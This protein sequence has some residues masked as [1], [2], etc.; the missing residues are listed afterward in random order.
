MEKD[1]AYPSSRGAGREGG[2]GHG[3]EEFGGDK[4]VSRG[5]RVA[6]G[7]EKE[8]ELK[9]QRDKRREEVTVGWL[10]FLEP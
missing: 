3:R 1:G 2:G 6:K 4:C 5:M 10:L 9:G 8:G 7:M